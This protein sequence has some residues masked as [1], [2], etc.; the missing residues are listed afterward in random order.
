M[1]ANEFITEGAV[2]TTLTPQ[3]LT[4]HGP[5]RVMTLINMIFKGLPLYKKDGT[6]VVIKKS[7]AKRI[8]DLY[9]ANQ[10]AGAVKLLGND[11]IPY[12]LSSFLKTAEFGGQAVPPT[13]GADADADSGTAPV[14]GIKPGQVFQ[15]GNIEKGTEITAEIAINLGA[16]KAGL[17]GK[18]IR[19]NQYLDTQGAVGAAIKQISKEI[20]SKQIPTIPNL[21]KKE[22]S[23]IQNYGFE[24]L[25]VQQL[26]VG[27]ADFPNAQG[28]Y[29]HLGTGMQD[30]M[31]Y[32]PSS[33][34]NPLA[35]SYA[36]HN[37]QTG[38]TI[39]IS[40][41]GAK[42]GAP[43][44]I[45]GLKL[46]DTMRKL[47]GK[48]PAITFVNL[49][50]KTTSWKQP[51]VAAN[52]IAE[53]YPGNLGE[54]E[55][56]LPFDDAFLAWAGNTWDTR[57]SG[58]PNTLEEIPRKYQR[59]YKLVQSSI[60]KTADNPLFYDV[61]NY[62]KTMLHSAVNGGVIP[63]FN[64]RMLEVLG[65]NFILL[66]TK[67]VGKPGI[68]KFVTDVTWPAKIRGSVTFEHKDPAPKWTSS[69]TWKLSN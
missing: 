18:K 42:G 57:N 44:S 32:F 5:D 69:I 50:Q 63:N 62:V 22:R 46:P 53:N 56:F 34:A 64:A 3:Q 7:E 66:Q 12:P 47:I 17:L 16:F 25:G 31:L 13:A 48:D 59:L 1:R 35:D 65:E 10:F 39:F 24:Y 58:V 41:K 40:S 29:K 21:S 45:N 2:Q 19:T 49:I 60:A 6:P 15:H 11:G 14:A 27:T 9:Q 38:N 52:W 8:R 33:A 68:G 43:S 61:R 26:V 36:L 55:K 20:D 37:S 4:K 67:Q 23:N 30:L 28:F 54:L 51:F